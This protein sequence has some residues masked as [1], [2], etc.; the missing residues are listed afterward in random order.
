LTPSG[1]LAANY[2]FTSYVKG[3]ITII[4]AP[5]SVQA[6]NV[7][8]FKGDK[9]PTS[10]TYTYTTFKN[11]D[12]AGSAFSTQPKSTVPNYSSQVGQYP[13]NTCCI[14]QKVNNYTFTYPGGTF[15]FVDP[16]DNNTKNIVPS[17]DCVTPVDPATNNGFPYVCE[18]FMDQ[19][20][21]RYCN[22]TTD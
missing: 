7:Y 4:P 8:Q 16:K 13:I 9:V 12:N 5:L 2:A 14:V 10:F 18:L 1:G 21:Q 22:R 15:V 3:T 11:S 17:L 6:N 20:E 19:S